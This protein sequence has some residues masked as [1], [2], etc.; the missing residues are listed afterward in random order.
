MTGDATSALVRATRQGKR[1][2]KRLSR[3]PAFLDRKP[4]LINKVCDLVIG[5]DRNAPVLRSWSAATA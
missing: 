3:K 2:L 5:P 4:T 1:T